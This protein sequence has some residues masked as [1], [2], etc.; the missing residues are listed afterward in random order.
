MPRTSATPTLKEKLETKKA[1][2]PPQLARAVREAAGATQA[3]VAAEL[4]VHPVTVARWEAGTRR[5][6]NEHLAAYVALLDELRG[7]AS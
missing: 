6:R 5:P 2:P 1:L 3:D 7:L 4:H